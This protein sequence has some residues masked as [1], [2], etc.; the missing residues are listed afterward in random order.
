MKNVYYI[1]M[2]D[3]T[4]Y[5]KKV[6][7]YDMLDALSKFENYLSERISVDYSSDEVFKQIRSCTLTGVFDDD[8]YLM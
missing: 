3:C 6:V 1:E 5:N 4:E 8:E 2:R 7:A